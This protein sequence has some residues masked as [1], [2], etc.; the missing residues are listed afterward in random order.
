MANKIIRK[1]GE[2]IADTI[3]LK[4]RTM[5]LELNL[6]PGEMV[7]IQDFCT[8]LKVSRSPV[9]DA[10]IR[11]E[12][13]ALIT[14][15]PQRGTM[16]SRIDMNR[17]LEERYIRECL[18]GC[19]ICLFTEN[20]NGDISPLQ[21]LIE[22]QKECALKADYRSFL[23]FD[24]AFHKFFF[25]GTNKL[26]SWETIQSACG[27]YRRIRLLSMMETEVLKNLVV[28]HETMLDLMAKKQT[29]PILKL[30]TTHLTNLDVE[31]LELVNR[32]PELFESSSQPEKQSTTIQIDFLKEVFGENK[33]FAALDCAAPCD[34]K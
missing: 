26:L 30:L 23:H 15:L 2:T 18:E 22:K 16:I 5:I 21:T 3:Y 8:F 10:L 20:Y 14:T 6:K 27:H 29:K 34:I 25:E 12:K 1:N 4:L 17:V 7:S 32:Y 28:E 33:M 31:R 11:L 19:T 9:R 24:D 13:E